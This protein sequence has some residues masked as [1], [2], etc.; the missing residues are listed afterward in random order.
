MAWKKPNLSYNQEANGEETGCGRKP[1][2][3]H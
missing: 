1:E 2:A 3:S